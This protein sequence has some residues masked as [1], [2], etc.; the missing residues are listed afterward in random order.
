LGTVVALSIGSTLFQDT[1]RE[2][3]H[4]HLSGLDV[5]EVRITFIYSPSWLGLNSHF[6]QI[7]RRVRESLSYIDELDPVTRTI[8]RSS[9]EE[10]LHTSLWFLVILAAAS[11]FFSF[12]IKETPLVRTQQQG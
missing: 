1:L 10:A 11:S 2:S 9:Y 6:L 5:D 12:F 3:L 8:V 4:S 7:V